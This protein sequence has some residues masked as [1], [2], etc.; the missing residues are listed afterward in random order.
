MHRKV[1]KLFKA[2]VW[3]GEYKSYY[4]FALEFL[5]VSVVTSKNFTRFTSAYK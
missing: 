2:A 4:T 1:V 3:L 5:V